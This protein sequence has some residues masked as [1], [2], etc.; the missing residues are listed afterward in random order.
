M[1]KLFSSTKIALGVAAITGGILAGAVPAKVQAAPLKRLV[2]AVKGEPEQGFDPIKGW[3]E[4]GHPLFQSTLIKHDANLKL[5][6]DLATK[7]E[8]SSDQRTWTIT[9]RDGV[10]FAD[11]KPLTAEDVAFTF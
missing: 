10:K 5:V 8:L 2:L 1:K 7:W 6:G 11:G 3:G 9:L 4:Y